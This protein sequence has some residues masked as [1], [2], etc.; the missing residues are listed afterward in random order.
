MAFGQSYQAARKSNWSNRIGRT[1]MSIFAPQAAF[2]PHHFEIAEDERG[3]WVAKDKEGLIGGC[4]VARRMPSVSHCSKWRATARAFG[5]SR[6]LN[7][8]PRATAIDPSRHRCLFI[9]FL[10]RGYVFALENLS[11]DR[12]L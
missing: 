12:F 7:R 8:D 2:T 6:G 3:H 1:S 10:W 4:S 9:R 11:G 5:C